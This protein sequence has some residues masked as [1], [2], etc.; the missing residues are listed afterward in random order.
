MGTVYLPDALAEKYPNAATK[1]KWQYVFPSTQL[2]EDPRRGI[3]RRHHRSDSAVHR[4]VKQ[5]V[6]LAGIEKRA[7]CHTLRHSFAT[8]LLKDGTDIRTIQKLLG[9]EE[10]QTT[11]K[12]VHVLEES[13]WH[14]QS[15]LDTLD[16][17][18]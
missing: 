15:P 5:A 10:L 8:H 6:D 17:A 2:S 7:T 1:W 14:V 9:H 3:V 4:A 12:Y 13:G 16:D 18:R 11:M